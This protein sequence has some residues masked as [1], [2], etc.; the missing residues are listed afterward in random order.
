MTDR[1]EPQDDLGQVDEVIKNLRARLKPGGPD[2]D[3]AALYG[4][5]D[6]V[7]PEAEQNEVQRRIATWQTWHDE[8]WTI[9][10][11]LGNSPI[12]RDPYLQK[13]Q[14]QHSVR[15]ILVVRP[16][17]QVYRGHTDDTV[18]NL[19]TEEGHYD[20][21]LPSEIATRV[22]GTLA[23]SVRMNLHCAHIAGQSDAPGPRLEVW[24]A[25]VLCDFT[26]TIMFMDNIQGRFSVS[27]VPKAGASAFS[28]PVAG[29]SAAAFVGDQWTLTFE[30]E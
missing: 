15:V 12:G 24:P 9:C 13:G 1:E 28:K 4:Y 30:N 6:R 20:L 5:I 8:Y 26:I 11:A 19:A 29:F 2:V 22:Y 21:P 18:W 16:V 25:P 27:P 7:L 14:F 23:Q 17:R 3:F 10:A